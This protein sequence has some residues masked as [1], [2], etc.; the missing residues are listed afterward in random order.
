MTEHED[1]PDPKK[2]KE[3]LNIVTEKVPDLLKE[4]SGVLYSPEQA[5]QFSLAAATFYKELKAAGMTDEQA[6][7]LTSQYMSTMNIGQAIKGVAH[8][9]WDGHC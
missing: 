3:I 2:I 6:F 4:L 7:E 1:M 8:H 9:K 5:K